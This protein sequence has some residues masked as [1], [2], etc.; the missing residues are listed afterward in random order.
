MRRQSR[1]TRARLIA[2][3][4]IQFT[5]VAGRSGDYMFRVS[6]NGVRDVLE[7][8]QAENDLS[9]IGHIASLSHEEQYGVECAVTAG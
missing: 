9:I 5:T 8:D 3:E 6:T 7:K 1:T 2:I 4:R